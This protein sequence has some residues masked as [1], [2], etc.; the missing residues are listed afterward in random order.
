MTRLTRDLARRPARAVVVSVIA[1]LGG[2]G[3]ASAA[4][5][6]TTTVIRGCYSPSGGAL[7]ITDTCRPGEVAI[8][9]NAEGPA[10]PAGPVGP[11]G[12]PGS[13]GAAG[14]AGPPGPTGPAGKRG[15]RGPVG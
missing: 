11:A 7:R 15:A 10:G 14:P 12:P 2:L 9:W 4:T 6:A 8:S 13:A 1:L 3:V 5:G